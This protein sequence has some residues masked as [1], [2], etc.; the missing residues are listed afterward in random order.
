M[1]G[2][3]G[4][5]KAAEHQTGGAEQRCFEQ[6]ANGD[7]QADF[8]QAGQDRRVGKPP[9]PRPP[10]AA[11][12]ARAQDEAE[13]AQGHQPARGGGREAEPP[14]AERR[15][16]ESSVHQHVA[17]RQQRGRADDAEGHRRR[18]HRE[19]VGEAA[20]GEEQADGGRGEADRAQKPLDVGQHSRID[21][22]GAGEHRPQPP[23]RLLQQR[24]QASHQ[25][26]SL[27]E[28]RRR[29][30]PPAGAIELRYR[31]RQRHHGAERGDQ[32]GCPDAG[33]DGD[34]A[35]HRRAKMPGEQDVDRVR[36]DGD[37]LRRDQRRSET[38]RRAHV[39]PEAARPLRA[40]IYFESP[41][42]TGGATRHINSF[43]ASERCGGGSAPSLAPGPSRR[44]LE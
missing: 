43:D 5:A 12:A 42:A 31:R 21:R 15:Q 37:H 44:S 3:D 14:R 33:A 6:R 11:I 32:R 4:R 23:Q 40:K 8:E 36:A 26:E 41:C 13:I 9:T 20:A 38:Q 35:Q 18:G 19:P 30:G 16:P 7:R 10:D 39:G 28:Q 34:R 2:D 24:A 25:P 17:D 1:S 29:V 27:A 22:D